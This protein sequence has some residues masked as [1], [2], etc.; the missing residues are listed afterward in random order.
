MLKASLSSA[1]IAANPEPGA[2]ADP[3]EVV[4]LKLPTFTVILAVDASR[5][6]PGMLWEVAEFDSM[7]VYDSPFAVYK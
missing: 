7:A 4:E 1:F 5:V 2:A 6:P 3:S